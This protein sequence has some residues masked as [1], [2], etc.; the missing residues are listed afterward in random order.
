MNLPLCNT[1]QGYSPPRGRGSRRRKASCELCGERVGDVLQRIDLRRRVIVFPRRADAEGADD[2]IAIANGHA[3]GAADAGL[4][5]AGFG[6][7]AGIGLEIADGDGAVFLRALAGDAFADG[8][9]AYHVQQLRRQPGLREEAQ[10]LRRLVQLVDGAGFGIQ[11]GERVAQDFFKVGLGHKFLSRE[12]GEGDLRSV[13][14][15]SH[16]VSYGWLIKENIRRF[17]LGKVAFQK[18]NKRIGNLLRLVV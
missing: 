9:D 15:L 10:E 12:G 18:I 11:L 7:A 5:G 4:F 16:S 2:F 13:S 17:I 6:H 1:Q 8:D 3:D 14:I